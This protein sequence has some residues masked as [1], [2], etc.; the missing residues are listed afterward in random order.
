[1]PRPWRGGSADGAEATRHLSLDDL[2]R[3]AE[4]PEFMRLRAREIL[5]QPLGDAAVVT[6]D[7]G[8]APGSPEQR[9]TP[10]FQVERLPVFR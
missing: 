9:I 6:F 8:H 10:G 1:M 4:G 5:V 2:R 7:D 3:G